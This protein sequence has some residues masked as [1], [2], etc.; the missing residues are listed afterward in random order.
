MAVLVHF[1]QQR[2]QTSFMMTTGFGVMGC[3]LCEP[4]DS[5]NKGLFSS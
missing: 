2:S 3:P 5:N 1:T 4:N